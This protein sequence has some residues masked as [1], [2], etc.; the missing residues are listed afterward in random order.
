VKAAKAVKA[1]TTLTFSAPASARTTRVPVGVRLVASGSAV[2]NGYVRLE[3]STGSGWTYAGRLLTGAD[4][5]G[6]GTLR[7]SGAA[8][9]RATY[10]GASSRTSAVSAVRAVRSPVVRAASA[11]TVGDLR[12]AA[13]GRSILKV[14]ARYVGTPYRYGATGPSAFDCSGFTRYV[15][16]KIGVRLPHNSGAQ[17]SMTRRVSKA[18]ARPGDLVSMPGHVGIYAGGGRMYDAPHAGSRV[19]LRRIYTSHYTLHRVV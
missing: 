1:A 17:A 5:T 11:S 14:A 13:I 10:A 12:G 2:R 16:G 7:V 3:K 9:L 6:S 18:A 4:G 19:T 15:Y 8:S